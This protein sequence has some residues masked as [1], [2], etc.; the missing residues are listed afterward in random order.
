LTQSWVAPVTRGTHK[1]VKGRW[2]SSTT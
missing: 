1:G 2:S